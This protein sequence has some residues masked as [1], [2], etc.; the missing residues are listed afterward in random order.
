[1]KVIHQF[2]AD[3]L[4]KGFTEHLCAMQCDA[5]TRAV[6]VTLTAGGTA[7]TP[8]ADT[9]V[10]VAFR[11]PDGKKGWYDKLPDRSSAC[12]VSGNVVTAVLAP[13]VLTA[14]GEVRATIVFQ[15]ADLHQLAT[16]GFSILVE[17]NPAAGT[18]ISNDYYAYST[19][20]NVSAAV[21]DMLQSLEQTKADIGQLIVQ[22]GEAV[23]RAEQEAGAA[24]V[25]DA[26]GAVI[27]AAD[28][29]DR[30]LQGLTL[31]GKTTQDGTPSIEVPAQ[32]ESAGKDGS[33]GV[34]VLGK[35]LF[36]FTTGGSKVENGT[37]IERTATGATFQGKDGVS[38]G[39]AAYSSGWAHLDR[40]TTLYLTA[41][42]VVTMSMDY[43]VLEKHQSANGYV[44]IHSANM[45]GGPTALDISKAEIGVK[46]RIS[47]TFTIP[48]DGEYKRTTVSL[49]SGKA[50]IE[51]VQ[52][53]IGTG[54]TEFEPYQAQVL[55]VS[56]PNG[57]PGIP[58]SSG[59]NYT[60]ES[61]QAWVCDEV[62]FAR[63]VYVQRINKYVCTGEEAWS[64]SATQYNKPGY[65]R[66]D[67]KIT[68]H[69][70][71]TLYDV[72]SSH[73]RYAGVA[74]VN[75]SCGMNVWCNKESGSLQ[76][77]VMSQHTTA[78]EL[79]A[80]L[81]DQYTA[82]TPVT[83]LYALAAPVETPLDADVL[84]AY[85]GLHTNKPST[86]VTN[87]GGAGQKVTYVAD[88]KAYIDNRFTALQNAILAAGANI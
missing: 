75:T 61:G 8:P 43:T 64:K 83:I 40:A 26:S 34:S 50:K 80:W 39:S 38:P 82:G 65:T 68:A 19:M 3:L 51:N 2:T 63:G 33:L 9:A 29:S 85:A 7:W 66:F 17:K 22:A 30:P 67:V 20:E 5:M 24:I 21:D 15:D 28:S 56:T 77:R 6:A 32:L 86:T 4:V 37:V 74:T 53:E 81:A 46:Y 76:L 48:S 62:D 13:E 87:D 55:S 59:G 78:E 71:S 45:I 79:A 54:A 10:S 49:H 57:L 60:D 41:G 14:A 88:A 11:K 42:T 84:A 31:Y 12:S 52:W 44:N 70:G 72:M 25:C 18:S 35:N 69:P 47:R 1:M 36:L 27:T 16:F 58:V 73:C 23:S